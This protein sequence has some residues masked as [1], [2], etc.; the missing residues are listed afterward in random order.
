MPVPS[1]ARPTKL[2]NMSAQFSCNPYGPLQ[3]YT[4]YNSTAPD[5]GECPTTGAKL[6]GLAQLRTCVTF[7]QNYGLA[8]NSF[9]LLTCD[10]SPL[11]QF[12]TNL[13]C[14]D[15]EAP[16]PVN[17]SEC[18]FIALDLSG[19]ITCQSSSE[20][21]SYLYRD[22]QSNCSKAPI[23]VL[24][25]STNTCVPLQDSLSFQADCSSFLPYCHCFSGT[26]DFDEQGIDCGG[27][28]C[29]VCAGCADGLQNGKETGIDCGGP[30]CIAC[31]PSCTD[32][33]KNGLEEGLDC[34]GPVCFACPGTDPPF[35]FDGK[36]SKGETDVDC[37]D[38]YCKRRCSEGQ[39]C[40][41]NSDCRGS[42][43]GCV[44]GKCFDTTEALVFNIVFAIFLGLAGAIGL[45]QF[46]AS[47]TASRIQAEKSHSRE[48][49]KLEKARKAREEAMQRLQ[50]SEQ[51]HSRRR[52]EA[53]GRRMWLQQQQQLSQRVHGQST[54]TAGSLNAGTADTLNALDLTIP[55]TGAK[56]RSDSTGTA[57]ANELAAAPPLRIHIETESY[58]VQNSGP[59][60]LP[61]NLSGLP[62]ATTDRPAS[63]ITAERS[64][65]SQAQAD[66]LT[67][68]STMVEQSNASA[69]L[70]TSSTPRGPVSAPD[71]RVDGSELVPN[72]SAESQ[73]HKQ[74]ADNLT[75]SAPELSSVKPVSHANSS[76]PADDSFDAGL[77][78]D[79][80][81]MVHADAST[82]AIPSGNALNTS[83]RRGVSGMLELA[84][85]AALN[86]A[87][88]ASA[89]EAA[90]ASPAPLQQQSPPVIFSTV[91][92]LLQNQQS[93]APAPTISLLPRSSAVPARPARHA[94]SSSMDSEIS[95]GSQS[96]RRL[97]TAAPALPPRSKMLSPSPSNTETS[98]D[99]Y[100][101]DDVFTANA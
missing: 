82:R 74:S 11:A 98:V 66:L 16:F 84:D 54:S 68:D 101:Q 94:P 35:C 70:I 32:G 56:S 12:Y 83:V 41:V 13:D 33:V 95:T 3:F 72:A 77:D 25:G 63:P 28:G 36:L 21:V 31:P 17:N 2:L 61:L 9:R 8:I 27:V 18:A 59:Q 26:K 30:D 100:I 43:S 50:K 29:P 47:F 92:A 37:G 87:A 23:A 52:C 34:G 44:K 6:T 38:K 55:S 60:Q 79:D 51:D 76:P 89:V 1:P 64:Q 69:R 5:P 62:A 40:V 71:N 7:N 24:A 22:A 46:R 48:Q 85:S 39:R 90:A 42:L 67:T 58:P 93:R 49:T 81:I 78:V 53:L 20:F 45:L 65:D 88:S 97:T 86:T 99:R 10:K 75:P 19:K 4:L 91:P 96:Q 73:D 14:S 57:R 80:V 15:S